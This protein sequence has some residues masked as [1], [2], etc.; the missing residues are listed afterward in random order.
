MSNQKTIH[1]LCA[2]LLLSA[3]GTASGAIV[4]Y[5]PM[6]EGSGTAVKDASGKGHDGTLTGTVNWVQG[7]IGTALDFPGD[8]A[9]PN[10][11]GVGKWDPSE[12]TGQVSVA[13]WIKW[14]G[15]NSTSTFQGIVTKSDG[16]FVAIRWQLTMSNSTNQIGFGFGGGAP[17]YPAAAP[18][19]GE[20]E[21]V[22]FTHDGTTATMYIN[23]TVQTTTSAVALGT[24]TGA[25]IVIGALNFQGTADA[26]FKGTIDEV[27][28]F[29]K[30]LSA[31]E[32][33][34]VMQGAFAGPYK[35]RTPAPANLA[36]DVSRGTN[37]SWTAG[38]DAVS[39]DIY[40]GTSA[41]D[42][43]SATKADSK[44]V[45]AAA[46]QTN[47][48]YD[49]VG[50]LELG[51]TYYWRVD[52]VNSADSG[53]SDEGRRLE[54]HR[55]TLAYAVDSHDITATAS[56]QKVGNYGPQNTVD[57]SGMVGDV[58]DVNEKAMW[59]SLSTKNG[60]TMPAWIRYDFDKL[61]K[62]HEMWVWNFNGGNESS[63]GLG[64][65]APRSSICPPMTSGR[66]WA[67]SSSPKASPRTVTPTIRRFRSAVSRPSRFASRSTKP[68][69]YPYYTG[70]S[71]VRFF[72][73]PVWAKEPQPA[74]DSTDIDPT[75]VGSDLAART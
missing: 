23:G 31:A 69:T 29:D 54:L 50:H 10:Y 42:I 41:A 2:V 5:Y 15:A 68:G 33:G 40:F 18:P 4:A 64:P 22:V 51:Q 7:K 17:V 61:Y 11:V 30:A 39:H 13:T 47:T 28:L 49:P 65:G 43:Q 70:L 27:Y 35:S 38:K 44:G 9:T 66:C 72:Y 73:I 53:Q 67:I 56:S 14:A 12:S 74:S 59:L 57:G 37:L 32:V 52:E 25:A 55:R 34:E 62:L 75:T 63:M 19:V 8:A 36:T 24:G 46:G 45:L 20:W 60:G 1:W 58:A 26:P 48:T 21:H 6:D 71:E 3:I 16:V